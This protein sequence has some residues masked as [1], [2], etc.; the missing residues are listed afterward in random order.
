VRLAY[1]DHVTA[2]LDLV[3]H[4]ADRHIASNTLLGLIIVPLDDEFGYTSVHKKSELT[5][6]DA[7]VET[8]AGTPDKVV[9]LVSSHSV[10]SDTIPAII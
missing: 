10:L 1:R 7:E 2:E 4:S 6:T 8:E 9:I 3:L 5:D